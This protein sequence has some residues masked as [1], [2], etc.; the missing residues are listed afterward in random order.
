MNT[1]ANVFTVHP[2]ARCWPIP[3][4]RNRPDSL[5]EGPELFQGVVLRRPPAQDGWYRR[6]LTLKG[7][8]QIGGQETWLPWEGIAS[9]MQMELVNQAGLQ[10][11]V[12]IWAWPRV[13]CC[14][15]A[16]WPFLCGSCANWTKR[17]FFYLSVYKKSKSG[18][19]TVKET[20]EPIFFPL[21]WAIGS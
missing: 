14:F 3:K 20:R 2:H 6:G 19:G 9:L 16:S 15:R 21:T 5:H 17:S 12:L 4:Q 7:H 1:F 10:P 13:S 18:V 11:P 8:G